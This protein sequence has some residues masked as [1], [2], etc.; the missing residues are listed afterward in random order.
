MNNSVIKEII[1]GYTR[2]SG[3]RGLERKIGSVFRKSAKSIA[4]EEEY[5]QSIV[6]EDIDKLLGTKIFDREKY[7]N[8]E[9]AGIVTGLAWTSV[10]GEILTIESSLNKGK[11]KLTVSGQ[12]GNVMKE[13][14][15]LYTSPSPRDQRGSRMPSSA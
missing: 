12:L 5:D 3:V 14:C 2:E 15:L 1:D 7:E 8:E 6:A 13:S 11:G 10:G 4:L 9:K